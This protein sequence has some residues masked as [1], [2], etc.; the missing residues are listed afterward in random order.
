MSSG[1]NGTQLNKRGFIVAKPKGKHLAAKT[2]KHEKKNKKSKA[3]R[4]LGRGAKVVIALLVVLL[5]SGGGVYAYGLYYFS[6]HF[7]PNTTVNGKQV[8]LMSEDEL[9][10]LI[11][12]DAKDYTQTVSVGDFTTT[13]TADQIGFTTD[14][15]AAAEAAMSQATQDLYLWP[16][17]IFKS[18]TY[19]SEAASSFDQTKLDDALSNAVDS[20]NETAETP[21]NA[22]IIYD[23][24]QGAFVIN[25]EVVGNEVDKDVVTSSASEAIRSLSGDTALDSSALTQPDVTSDSPELTAAVDKA[26]QM[27][28][29]E[30]PLTKDDS[31]KATVDKDTIAGWIT[32]D[33]DYNVSVDS[34]KVADYVAGVA[35]EF[36][37][38]DDTYTYSVKTDELTQSIADAV[39]NLSS[40]AIEV[41]MKAKAKPKEV[42]S[43][44]GTGM[45]D[46]DGSYIDIDLTNQ[47]ARLYGED[48]SIK[49][50]SYI[51]SGN[52]SEGRGTPTGT[53]AIQSKETN[54]TLVGADEDKDGT[55]DYESFVNYW[56]PFY[57]GSYGLHDATW[58]SSFGGTIYQSGGSHGCVN[59]PYDNAAQLFSLVSVGTTVKIHY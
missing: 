51:V 4:G 47:Y 37:S 44:M 7:L 36:A 19:V 22:S 39:S 56:M 2:A 41:P 27:L 58:R 42:T 1:A 38:S 16:V 24:E 54:V 20:Y 32:I 23:E 9:A 5:V 15:E 29:V 46:G 26:N 3:R 50:E 30:I 45:W 48:G 43:S 35:D 34:D 8:G 53:F 55:P 21:Q 14:G 31:T 13:L 17:E 52:T 12:D 40:E 6:D 57:A 18:H 33:D 49:W 25:P 10:S 11:N 28:T 59:L